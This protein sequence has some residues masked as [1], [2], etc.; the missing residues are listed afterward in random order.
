MIKAVIFDL[1]GTLIDSMQVWYKV[2][3]QFLIENGIENP[4]P[5]ISEQVK[6]MT[7]FQSS[8]LFIDEFNLKC[9][10]EYVI[11]RIEELVRIEYAERIPLKPFVNETLDVLDSMNIPYC[12]ATATYKSL[13]QAVLKRCGIIDRFRF[14]L[15][16]VEY[17]NGKKFPDIFLG[18]CERFGTKP[19]ETLVVEDS[20]HCIETAKKAGFPVVA[21]Y[22]KASEIDRKAIE[23]TADYYF[24]SINK[25]RDLMK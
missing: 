15:T 14:I 19:Y 12:I 8:Q 5:E 10:Q 21:V 17:P 16:D 6:K 23:N 1:D 20:L 22:D 25:I 24:E 7:I 11:N 13:A 3:K 9:T 18:A 2:D 4:P